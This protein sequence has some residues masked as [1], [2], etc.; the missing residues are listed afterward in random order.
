[1]IATIAVDDEP[2]S[3]E[4]IETYCKRFDFLRYEKGFS[5]TAA[6]LQYIGKNVVDLLFLDIRMPALSGMEFYNALPHKPMLIFATSYSE[7]ALESYDLSAVDYLLKPFTLARFEKAVQKAREMFNLVHNATAT[8]S[9]RSLLLKADHGLVKIILSD[10][11]F[12]EGLDNYLKIHLKSGLPVIVRL[13]LKVLTE[14]LHENE[15]VRVH[16]SYIVP[17]HRIQSLKQKTITVAGEEIPVGKNYEDRL[18]AIL[19]KKS[20]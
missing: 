4:L 8:P 6:A 11:L 19:N 1:M 12:I 18:K 14:K 10:I 9:A 15:F 5:S 3:L 17:I 2:L 20:S 13:T 16:R 7:Y